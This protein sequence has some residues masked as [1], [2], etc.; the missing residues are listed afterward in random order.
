ML[1]C[2]IQPKMFEWILTPLHT[3]VWWDMKICLNNEQLEKDFREKRSITMKSYYDI[4]LQYTK[5]NEK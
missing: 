5:M 1:W 4:Y 3:C 2:S